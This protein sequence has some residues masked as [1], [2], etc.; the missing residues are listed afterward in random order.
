MSGLNDPST[1]SVDPTPEN[2]KPLQGTLAQIMGNIMQSGRTPL[3]EPFPG[4]PN[5]MSQ[6]YGTP[7][8]GS[9][10]PGGDSFFRGPD[11]TVQP[12]TPGGQGRPP[13]E[14]LATSPGGGFGGIGMSQPGTHN[15]GPFGLGAHELGPFQPM[16]EPGP[17]SSGS[18]HNFTPS[19]QNQVLPQISDGDPFGGVQPGGGDLGGGGGGGGQPVVQPTGTQ[20]KGGSPLGPVDAGQAA[21][22][23]LPQFQGPHAAPLTSHQ[24]DALSGFNKLFDPQQLVQTQEIQGAIQAGLGGNEIF[25]PAQMGNL[26][27][28]TQPF[29]TRSDTQKNFFGDL[30]GPN[31]SAEQAVSRDLDRVLAQT[32]AEASAF[33]LNPG[34]TDRTDRSISA[35]GDVMNR[36]RLGQQQNQVSALPSLMQSDQSPFAN[37]MAVREPAAQRAQQTLGMLPAFSNLPFQQAQAMFGMGEAARGVADTELARR[38]QELART[39]GAGLN[40]FLQLFGAASPQSTG[41]GPSPL[42]QMGQL[43]QGAAAFFV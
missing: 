7:P 25:N 8:Q 40:Q 1:I 22:F 35:A 33:G 13:R 5:V 16:T 11:G 9:P 43:A 10:G 18:R 41:F 12:G 17:I 37:F 36:F 19:F 38:Q 32:R 4:L 23:D 34:S 28:A 2:L 14:A 26:G 31:S 42:S 3:Q 27:Q 6:L 15:R 39:Q 21:G 29:D 20:F 30:F 24:L